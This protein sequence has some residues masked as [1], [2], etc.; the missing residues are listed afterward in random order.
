MYTNIPTSSNFHC[1]FYAGKHFVEGLA[2]R[3]SYSGIALQLE[4]ATA[5]EL[6]EGS[7]GECFIDSKSGAQT[8]SCG[9]D[10]EVVSSADNS[11]VLRFNPLNDVQINFI[12][13]L[14]S[15]AVEHIN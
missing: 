14:N 1:A 5:L 11:L 6:S 4:A 7:R 12:R 10:C 13:T 8:S 9:F 15:S 2:R 3:V